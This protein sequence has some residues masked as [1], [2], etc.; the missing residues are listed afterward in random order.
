MF[1]LDLWV[2]HVSDKVAIIETEPQVCQLLHQIVFQGDC[3]I[4]ERSLLLGVDVVV[5]YL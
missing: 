1:H 3:L 5:F 2:C 4:L